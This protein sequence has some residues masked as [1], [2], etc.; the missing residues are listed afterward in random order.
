MDS[1]VT[2]VVRFRSWKEY[3]T[4]PVTGVQVNVGVRSKVDAT[5]SIG[6]GAVA[7]RKSVA[8]LHIANRP[9]ASMARTQTRYTEIGKSADGVQ[10]GVVTFRLRT[11]SF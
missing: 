4:A 3:V 6:V 1:T 7:M 9:L 2:P 11:T 5:G 10:F 8:T